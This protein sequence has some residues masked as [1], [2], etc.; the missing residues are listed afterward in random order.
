MHI[1]MNSIV[2]IFR[3]IINQVKSFPSFLCSKWGPLSFK[4]KIFA[5]V[6]IYSFLGFFAI[7]SNPLGLSDLFE[8]KSQ[9]AVTKILSPWYP[10]SAQGH[11]EKVVVVL[12]D[13]QSLDLISK[14]P[15]PQKIV[16]A[17]E[18]P[19]LYSDHANILKT[20]SSLSQPKQFFIDIEFHRIRN[21]DKSFPKLIKTLRV[22]KEE[23]NIQFSHAVGSPGEEI[24]AE[25]NDQLT[26]VSMPTYNGWKGNFVAL[27]QLN[28]EGKSLFSPALQ[29]YSNLEPQKVI[30]T[31]L[32]DK[33]MFVFWDDTF[34]SQ[35]YDM[36]SINY[37]AEGNSSRILESL[38][39]L[40]MQLLSIDDDSRTSY[41]QRVVHLDEL[42]QM[43]NQ[44]K[45]GEEKIKAIFD[46][47]HVFYGADYIALGDKVFSPVHGNIPGIFYHAMAFENLLEFGD[48]YFKSYGKGLDLALWMLLA[49]LFSVSLVG[50]E[51]ISF[52][53]KHHSITVSL[54]V[55]TYILIILLMVIFQRIAPANL[56]ALLGLVGLTF[57]IYAK[58]EECSQKPR[59]TRELR[60]NK[61]GRIS[62]K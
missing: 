1:P 2:R 30:D 14:L 7:Y 43:V 32:F 4:N 58:E 29:M 52:V 44:G 34:D 47:A 15:A 40:A 35:K 41:S 5:R 17:N 25:V 18:W 53:R 11:N 19:I 48:G 50:K 23:N 27:H 31:T 13:A 54:I 62:E 21:T 20:I 49:F 57:W 60:K 39:H 3:K 42:Q 56:V 28:P 12:V 22:L 16:Q 38:K 46:G 59:I 8:I 10:F 45:E 36:S 55:V 37:K 24:G 9:E 33:E 61:K 6:F 26:K 51:K